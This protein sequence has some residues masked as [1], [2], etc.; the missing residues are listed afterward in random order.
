MI[1]HLIEKTEECRPKASVEL[2]NVH[3]NP[4]PAHARQRTQKSVGKHRRV[5]FKVLGKA[6]NVKFYKIQ[7][8]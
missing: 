7:K 3:H 2:I 4:S 8:R 6:M 5:S 1:D